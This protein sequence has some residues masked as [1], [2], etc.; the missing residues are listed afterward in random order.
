M[1]HTRRHLQAALDA[2]NAEFDLDMIRY[3]LG[4]PVIGETI[5][6]SAEIREEKA[7]FHSPKLR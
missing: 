4:H 1:T 6:R 3:G 7:H 5:R 2:C